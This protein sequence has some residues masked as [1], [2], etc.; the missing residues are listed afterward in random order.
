MVDKQAELTFKCRAK[1]C[2]PFGLFTNEQGI[3]EYLKI[4][5]YCLKM[6]EK[7]ITFDVSMHVH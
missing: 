5:N 6:L 7:A 4:T 3:I 1:G 2:Y